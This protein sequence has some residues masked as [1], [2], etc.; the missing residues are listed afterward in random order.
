[1]FDMPPA[2]YDHPAPHMDVHVLSAAR[3]E[4]ICRGFMKHSNPIACA[5]KYKNI[6]CVI[7]LPRGYADWMYRH[8]RAHCNGWKH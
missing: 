3:L 4:R 5:I 8:E 2:Q 1:M 6:K 7:L